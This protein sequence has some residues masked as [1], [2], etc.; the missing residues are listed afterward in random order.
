MTYS[1]I[2][3]NDPP[4]SFTIHVQYFSAITRTVRQQSLRTFSI[5][6]WIFSLVLLVDGLPLLESTLTPSLLSWNLLCHSSTKDLE[7]VS[8]HKLLEAT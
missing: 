1:L 2:F 7:I 6:S 5:T 8:L 4:H 3:H